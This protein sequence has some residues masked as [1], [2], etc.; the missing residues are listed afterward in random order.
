MQVLSVTSEF[1]P[2]I[3]TGGLADVAGALPAALDAELAA[4]DARPIQ[5]RTLLPG[6]PQVMAGL[7]KTEPVASVDDLFGGP[8]KLLA[9]EA[10]GGAELIV[11]DAP[12]LYDRPGNPY[13]GA[14]GKDW[15]DNHFRFGALS[16]VA[17]RIGLG[18]I[19]GYRPDVIH[20]H[21]W[22]AGLVPVYL[23]IG[24][25]SPA[26]VITI[27]N[28]AFQGVFPAALLSALK[29]PTSSFTLDGL[30][31]WGKISFLK[32]GLSYADHLTTVSPTYAR[33]ICTPEHGMGLDG[34]LRERSGVLTGITNGI[35]IDIWNPADDPNII[36]PYSNRSLSG[37]AANKAALQS[38]FN[39][40]T[41]IAAPLFC[42]VSRLTEQKGFDL[43]LEALST[44]IA[45][46]GQLA[47]IGSGDAAL[48]LA[49]KEAVKKNPGRI[50]VVIGY[51][52]QIS[53]QLQAGADAIIVPS[54]FEPCG[55]TQLY[56]LRYGTLPIVARVGGLADT[57]IDANQAA[58]LDNVATGFQFTPDSVADLCTALVRAFDLY[59]DQRRWQAVQRRAMSRKVDWSVPAKAYADLYRKLDLTEVKPR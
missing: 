17:S 51:D 56:G 52:E 27:H 58:L 1:F 57:V 38:R 54:R 29:L 8:A 49:F 18:L 59:T 22:Q 11:I 10:P 34:V 43:L 16:W 33:E 32:G 55:L 7:K 31:F 35:D 41:D 19:D 9:S 24:P 6:Y 12:H 23:S 40:V 45:N 14:D 15:P 30:E 42:V 25:S 13:L 21:D 4:P 5:M 47:M 36:K 3:K 44:I 20:G 50:G 46:G 2:L 39:L 53:H 26:T 28:L 48:E 37:K